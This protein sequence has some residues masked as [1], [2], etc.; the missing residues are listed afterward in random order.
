MVKVQKGF[1][2]IELMIVIAIIGIL[3]AVAVPQYSQYTKRARFAEVV[4]ASAPIKTGI[5]VC[6]QSTS[7]LA[8]CDT[9]ADIGVQQASVQIGANVNSAAIAENTAAVTMTAEATL[10]SATYI[11]TPT[12]TAA[13]NTIQWAVTGTCKAA[14]TKYC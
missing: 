14:A 1:T 2:L 9:W 3:A 5:E 4:T 13:N 6:I 8:V 7:D 10:E 12:Y 11:I